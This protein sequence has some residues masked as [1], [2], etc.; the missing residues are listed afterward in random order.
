MVQLDRT[1]AIMESA[2]AVGRQEL[3]HFLAHDLRDSVSVLQ[4]KEILAAAPFDES[5]IM[6][7]ADAMKRTMERMGIKRAVASTGLTPMPMA[8]GETRADADSD[9]VQP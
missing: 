1:R 4:A 9:E 8:K 2:E 7:G 5:S 6:S 3:A